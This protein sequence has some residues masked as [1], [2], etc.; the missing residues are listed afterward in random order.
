VN[1]QDVTHVLDH[2]GARDML[3]SATLL[4][5]AYTGSDGFPRVI[6]IGFYWNGSEIVICTAATA[7]KV[8][9]LSSR[10]N[11]AV[12]IDVGDTPTEAK[13]LLVRGL[14]TVEIVDGVPDEYIAGSKKVLDA[15]QMAEFERRV[16]S[17]YERMARI[18]IQPRWAR[19]F[20]F[21]AGRLPAFLEKLVRGG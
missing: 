2:P 6:P 18:S 17:T 19:F 7:P 15:G 1:E 21:G 10:P 9:A 4:R 16:R 14:A 11:V 3:E 12:T 13:A 20:D 8:K 5:L